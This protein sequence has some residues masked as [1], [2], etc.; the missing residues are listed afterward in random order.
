MAA[1]MAVVIA[2]D[3]FFARRANA[4][5]GNCFFGGRGSMGGVWGR[6]AKMQK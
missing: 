4:N 3:V 6:I 5:S 2:I 1:Y